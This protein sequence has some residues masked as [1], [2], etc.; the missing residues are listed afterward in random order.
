M[1]YHTFFGL[2]HKNGHKRFIHRLKSDSGQM[3]DDQA[4]VHKYAVS[5]YSN[6]LKCEHREEQAV[7]QS[8]YA[9]LPQV[10]QQSNVE[11]EAALSSDE[12]YVALHSVQSGKA[13]GIDGPPVDFYKSFWSVVGGICLQY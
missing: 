6:L 13:P 12:L 10:E 1:S 9:G 7:S 5:F 3:L 11:L 8:F 4:A 2:K